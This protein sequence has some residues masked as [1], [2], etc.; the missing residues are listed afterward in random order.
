VQLDSQLNK[1]ALEESNSRIESLGVERRFLIR[2]RPD[3][4]F[5]NREHTIELQIKRL[6][7]RSR[8]VQLHS[9]EL[10]PHNLDRR[11]QL[12]PGMS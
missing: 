12:I 9:V 11:E 7:F 2:S 4:V 1:P 8:K 10:D 6:S 3:N 5:E